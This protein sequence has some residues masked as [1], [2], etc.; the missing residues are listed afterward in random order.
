[1]VPHPSRRSLLG[2]LG[3][4]VLVGAAGCTDVLASARGATDVV[5]HNE[6][7]GVL[8]VNL[9]VTAASADDPRIDASVELDP[10]TR[11]T[12]N[13]D[14]LM[15]ADYEVRVTATALGDGSE[16]AE[17]HE[18]KDADHTLHVLLSEQ[19]VFAVQVG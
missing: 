19:V 10:N 16:T 8:R 12:F 13:N 14:V 6:S 7:A 3:T 4:A 2:T 18:W 15:N 17:T 9:S 1:M 11:H 5:L